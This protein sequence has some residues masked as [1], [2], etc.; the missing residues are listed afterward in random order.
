MTT[1]LRTNRITYRMHRHLRNAVEC[2]TVT[3]NSQAG[4][5]CSQ[6]SEEISQ[7]CERRTH[8]LDLLVDGFQSVVCP[9]AEGACRYKA[10][11]P[12]MANE[13]PVRL[14]VG[15]YTVQPCFM[16]LLS[17]LFVGLL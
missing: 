17:Q 10:V 13:V 6:F 9:V 14:K 8:T 5:D 3:L 12:F 11:D 1:V 4:N 15:H 16:Q 7:I 2:N